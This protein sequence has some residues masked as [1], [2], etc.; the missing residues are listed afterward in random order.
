[1]QHADCSDADIARVA[2]QTRTWGG[3]DAKIL[4]GAD[5][6]TRA[7]NPLTG[8]TLGVVISEDDA[9][10][11][12]QMRTDRDNAIPP[13]GGMLIA[14]LAGLL[15][16]VVLGYGGFHVGRAYERDRI[17]FPRFTR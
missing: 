2:R 11:L 12:E 14:A 17:D 7:L 4:R 1:M 3:Q 6:R 10:L 15:V 13:L 5:G 8:S 16:V 9:D